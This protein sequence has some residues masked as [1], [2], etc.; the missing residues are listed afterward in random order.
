MVLQYPLLL[1]LLSSLASAV[2]IRMVDG[3]E[4]NPTP[5]ASETQ[6]GA[7]QARK[8]CVRLMLVLHN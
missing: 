7:Y 3:V 6:D 5:P 4:R 1:L 2:D 8:R